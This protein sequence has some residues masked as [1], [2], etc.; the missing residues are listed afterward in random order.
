[1][2]KK[3]SFEWIIPEAVEIPGL[4]S[5]LAVAN[6]TRLIRNIIYL[7]LAFVSK[8]SFQ[9]EIAILTYH[10]VD[11][12]DGYHTVDPKEFRRQIEYLRK[13]YAIVS[14]NDM[15]E[16]AKGNGNLPRKAVAITFDDGYHDFYLNVYPYFVKNKLCATVF[17]TTGYTGKEWR[18]NDPPIKMLSWKEIEEISEKNI[19]IGAHTVTHPNLREINLKKAKN[20]ILTSKKEIESY[21][22]KKARYFS[23]P[24]GSYTPEIVDIVK[25]SSFKGGF[26][27][28]GT[29]R[30]DLNVFVLNRV[31]VDSSVSFMLFK[32]RL[33]RAVDWFKSL[34][35]IVKKIL[36][37]LPFRVP[38]S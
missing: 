19:E 16:F 14:L 32:A 34:E 3:N 29:I 18:F 15:T 23:Y 37:K 11:S 2:W 25:S 24:F 27:G 35:Q 8:L 13:N 33:T 4:D 6:L 31:Q 7:A 1:M 26:G 28:E 12:I 36:V 17:V 20:E 10:S 21:T 22:K 5:T 38:L 9:R 30:K